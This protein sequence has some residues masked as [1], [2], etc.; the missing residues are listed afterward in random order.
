MN[1]KIYLYIISRI[2]VKHIENGLGYDS[3][4]IK[5]LRNI[6]LLSKNYKD[7]NTL[8]RV[9]WNNGDIENCIGKLDYSPF[10]QIEFEKNQMI[11]SRFLNEK[12]YRSRSN[13]SRMEQ[14]VM[15]IE[16]SNHFTKSKY[17]FLLF[18]PI[19]YLI[20]WKKDDSLFV[21]DLSIEIEPFHL[22]P[23]HDIGKKNIFGVI[24][25]ETIISQNTSTSN[26]INASTSNII[27]TSTSNI[28]NASTSNIIL[29]NISTSNI[30]SKNT[31]KNT[32]ENTPKNTTEN[33]SKNTT[34]NMTENY[35]KWYIVAIMIGWFLQK[36][37]NER[38]QEHKEFRNEVGENLRTAREII[39]RKLKT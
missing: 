9:K 7:G 34:E 18:V 35:E 19:L 26:I 5:N 20:S 10:N 28:I 16:N 36:N 27:N 14:P 8:I 23:C 24:L 17:I 39:K 29:Q 31:P 32:T 33:T 25:N 4:Y 1:S 3:I 12:K 21:L 11:I 2:F 38:K 6:W 30:I 15:I 13:D 37:W 22:S